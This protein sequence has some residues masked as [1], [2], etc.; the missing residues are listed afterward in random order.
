MS[1]ITE[2]LGGL[3]SFDI[4]LK[5]TAPRSLLDALD[6]HGH[7]IVTGSRV[8]VD[9]LGASDLLWPST[10]LF[11]G[12]GGNP[13]WA[14]AWSGSW[15]GIG[16]VY[17]ARSALYD[18]AVYSGVIRQLP[19]GDDF[20]VSGVGMLFWLGD[21]EKG[22][23]LEQ[24]V[25]LAGADFETAVRAVKPRSVT[26]GTIFDV[27]GTYTGSHRWETAREALDYII[28][29][30][31]AEYRVN[32]D[33]SLD[34]GTESQLY[35]TS[36]LVFPSSVT[37]PATTLYPQSVIPGAIAVRHGADEL[38]LE[39]LVG[40]RVQ[41]DADVE[42]LTTRVLVMAEG[43]GEQVA[44]GEADMTSE[45][46][47]D[48]RDFHGNPVE[49]T[50]M[51][52]ESETSEGNADVRARLQLNRFVGTRRQIRISSSDYRI[53]GDYTPGKHLWMYDPDAGLFDPANQIT[54][55]GQTIYPTVV[56]VMGATWPVTDRMGVYWRDHR[57][58][59]TDITEHIQPG[60]GETTLDVGASRRTLLNLDRQREA[61][62][63]R[64]ARSN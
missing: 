25:H 64:L 19:R 50:R 18:A 48:Y 44:V 40:S 5:D 41:H 9:T 36:A 30:F 46:D 49:F 43:E 38:D 56:R 59:I 21:G 37:W 58:R 13:A 57:G 29:T 20:A 26:V 31:G 27:G 28:E 47:P 63:A 60:T 16:G 32:P 35:A 6:F 51:V 10:D 42:D 1:T 14:E 4:R 39:T 7:I 23:V 54:F 33:G 17:P 3:G 62:R 15:W 24:P 8:D 45:Q 52:F 12:A 2:Q 11:P 61:L 55:D 53:D 34:A 22:P